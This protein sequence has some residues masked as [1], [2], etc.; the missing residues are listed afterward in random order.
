MDKFSV[1]IRN[2]NEERYIGY[3]IQSVID[4]LGEDI[5]LV[6]VDNESTDNSLKIVKTFDFVDVKEIQISKNNYTPGRSLNIGVEEASN[7]YLLILEC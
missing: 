6:I 5:E 2:R 7:P 3:A 1:L 4:K